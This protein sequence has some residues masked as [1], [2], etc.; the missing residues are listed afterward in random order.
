MTSNGKIA[1]VYA[2]GRICEEI[3]L[4]LARKGYDVGF[5]LR[6]REC[7]ADLVGSI[8]SLGARAIACQMEKSG[9]EELSR[10]VIEVAE[11][12]GGIDLLI[13]SARLTDASPDALLLDLDESDWDGAM[14]EARAFF[15]LLKY[16][17]PYLINKENSRVIVID[18]S[19]AGSAAA[20][21]DYVLSKTL[22]AAAG[23]IAAEF[24]EFGVSVL[25]K[26]IPDGEISRV[27]PA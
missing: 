13:F 3:C 1:F 10:S 26:N 22:E 24:S 19:D 18:T 12:L 6:S 4:N 27:L 21:P 9:A 2:D 7:Q 8:E 14:D 5:T 17:L 16:A 15:L 11:E 25:Y 20:L 23:R